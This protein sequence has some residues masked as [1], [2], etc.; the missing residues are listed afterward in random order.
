MPWVI[1]DYKSKYLD[2]SDP[3]VFR[4]LSKPIGAMDPQRLDEFR[5][6]YDETPHGAD[7]FL[8]GSHYSCPGYV[9]GFLVRTQP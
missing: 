1:K 6:R 4:D 2:L 9:I 8:Y 5:R 3:S 7:K